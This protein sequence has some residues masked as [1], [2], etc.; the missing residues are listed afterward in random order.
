MANVVLDTLVTHL[1]GDTKAYEQSL[2]TAQAT[3]QEVADSIKNRL[4]KA[5]QAIRDAEKASA[6]FAVESKVLKDLYRQN[7]I[8][9]D[10]YNKSLAGA[11]REME[12]V[13]GAAQKL[14]VSM[15]DMR[16]AIHA[17]SSMGIMPHAATRGIMQA[18]YMFHML[19]PMI[20]MVTQALSA[21]PMATAGIGVVIVAVGLLMRY[22]SQLSERHTQSAK[23]ASHAFEQMVSGSKTFKEALEGISFE[24]INKGMK[25]ITRWL[26]DPAWN[27]TGGMLDQWGLSIN[28]VARFFQ[29]ATME[30]NKQA[31]AQEEMVKVLENEIAARKIFKEL[32]ND[33]KLAELRVKAG[34]S[35][36]EGEIEKTVHAL[37]NQTATT[38]R[39]AYSAKAY[40]MALKWMQEQNLTLTQTLDKYGGKLNEITEK[41][42]DAARAKERR[43]QDKEEY[44]QKT[45]LLGKVQKG[46]E[47]YI[48]AQRVEYGLGEG[49]AGRDRARLSFAGEIAR[50]KT[51][52]D[53]AAINTVVEASKKAELE[54]QRAGL[55]P[56]EKKRQEMID[57]AA[58]S[59]RTGEKVTEAD[60]RRAE[61]LIGPALR[62]LE[63]TK[64]QEAVNESILSIRE[65]VTGM[66]SYRG[67]NK[68]EQERVKLAEALAKQVSEMKNVTEAQ[69]ASAKKQ[70]Q[71]DLQL[72]E[73]AQQRAHL[74]GLVDKTKDMAA[75]ARRSGLGDWEAERLKLIQDTGKAIKLNSETQAQAETRAAKILAPRMGDFSRL[76]EIKATQG[77]TEA[78]RQQGRE[79]DKLVVSLYQGVS[80]AERYG[81]AQELAKKMG[82]KAG[83][84]EKTKQLIGLQLEYH[85]LGQLVKGSADIGKQANELEDQAA[86]V[87][88]LTDATHRFTMVQK[89]AREN[90]LTWA[91]SSK[92]LAFELNR[93]QEAQGTIA[94]QKVWEENMHPLE[95]YERKMAEI[96]DLWRNGKLSAEIYGRAAEKAFGEMNGKAEKLTGTLYNSAEG[97]SHIYDYL[98]MINHVTLSSP[99]ALLPGKTAPNTPPVVVLTQPDSSI[100]K[101][102][103]DPWK[104]NIIDKMREMRDLLKAL[105]TK[106]G[107][108]IKP[109]DVPN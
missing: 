83:D 28:D 94:A 25:E 51:Q 18:Y 20:G 3:T 106:Q 35:K 82:D 11:Q 17:L 19:H 27:E 33:P 34:E 8:T 96:N 59:I 10:E 109:E 5:E 73:I 22:W 55:G 90:N 47:D 48:E 44:G 53:V 49:Q 79:I 4:G 12:S 64:K 38:N 78:A 40:G 6:K 2:K 67:M 87:G 103:K 7:A 30:E 85:R 98:Q 62:Q 21:M 69:V 100:L 81:M 45:A 39:S 76:Q 58:E 89:Y 104:A 65:K 93:I 56:I 50:K 14:H 101:G 99:P 91:E 43:A 95:K 15:R 32:A 97:M 71:A 80:A 26:S 74:Q 72:L 13:G 88:M 63:A 31:V 86:R 23:T 41:E 66:D 37:E 9:L 1:V 92:I 60:R 108:E 36:A 46:I 24:T 68:D 102:E 75:E 77:A 42:I 70:I 29:Q 105:A 107:A 57:S 52:G 61:G 16:H 54:M 84:I